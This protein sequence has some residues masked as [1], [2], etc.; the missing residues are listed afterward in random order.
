MET[1][2]KNKHTTAFTPKDHVD[3]GQYAIENG[4]AVIVLTHYKKKTEMS[5]STCNKT[6]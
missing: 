4:N 6:I 3:I 2:K 5:I 1:T